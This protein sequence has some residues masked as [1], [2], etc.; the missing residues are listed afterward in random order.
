MRNLLAKEKK[1]LK[2]FNDGALKTSLFNLFQC[3]VTRF[4][5]KL[6]LKLKKMTKFISLYSCETISN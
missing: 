3:S 4:V 6:C 2:Y 1:A 5:K